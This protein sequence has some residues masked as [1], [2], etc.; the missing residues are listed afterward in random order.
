MIKAKNRLIIA[1]VLNL[2]IVFLE[3]F[4]LFGTFFNNDGSFNWE[5]F[6]Y[7]THYSNVFVFLSSIYVSLELMK[8]ILSSSGER[9]SYLSR[10]FKYMSS[11]MIT[12]TFLVVIFVL[13]P[14]NGFRDWKF[15]LFKKNFIF[16]HL[17]CPILSILGITVFGDYRDFALKE[18][19]LASVPTA[20]YAVVITILNLTGTIEGPFTF[21]MVYKQSWYVSVF[22]F[23]GLVGGSMGIAYGLLWLA[24]K[25]KVAEQAVR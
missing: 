20:F 2:L 17:V 16:E 1:L 24:R 3:A 19:V 12:L 9:T 4:A 7:Y 21:A 6:Q 23:V 15:Y 8:E 10:L 18:T 13:V 25:I 22:W 11:S 14:S 5:F